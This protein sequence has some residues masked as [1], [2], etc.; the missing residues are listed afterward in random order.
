[1]ENILNV[2]YVGDECYV[3][4]IAVSI[5]SLFE[6]NLDKDAIVVYVLAVKKFSE[7]I[8]NKLND[9][10]S[11][12]HR[13][14]TIIM[15]EEYIQRIEKTAIANQFFIGAYGRIFIGDVL[16]T[17]VSN[18]LYLDGD[19][20]VSDSLSIEE[21]FD[22]DFLVKAVK[23]VW[24]NSYNKII[25]LDEKDFYYNS[26]V[27]AVNLERWRKERCGERLETH[28]K[29]LEKPYRFNDQDII[30][31]VLKEY[32]K[33]LQLKY[34][35]LYITRMYSIKQIYWYTEKNQTTFY[36][37]KEIDEAKQKPVIYHFAGGLLGKPW[38]KKSLDKDAEIWRC[39]KRKCR[40]FDCPLY[41]Q[42]YRNIK[43]RIKRFLL[44][45]MPPNILPYFDKMISKGKY[46]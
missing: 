12:Y 14:I 31:I 13:K 21:L 25:G 24:F 5:T 9:L 27:L 43:S 40:E 37:E 23:D 2:C 1:M 16:P 15:L 32:I 19:T 18:L 45:I 34:N 17:T 28:I 39:Y 35:M 8:C 4:I 38:Y 6:N 41:V 44:C 33:P 46:K 36:C 20:I 26:G 10:A 29:K 30:N 42:K 22:G 11:R 7:Q 3:P